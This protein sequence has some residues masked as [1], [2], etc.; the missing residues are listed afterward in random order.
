MKILISFL[1][2]LILF[3]SCG[4][5]PSIKLA[6][7]SLEA[8]VI[9]P[10]KKLKE[11]FEVENSSSEEVKIDSIAAMKGTADFANEVE[12]IVPQQSQSISIIY[13]SEKKSGQLVDSIKLFSNKKVLYKLPVSA[14]IRKAT[15]NKDDSTITIIPFNNSTSGKLSRRNVSRLSRTLMSKVSKYKNFEFVNPKQVIKNIKEDPS[16]DKSVTQT[17]LRKWGKILGVRYVMTGKV[18]TSQKKQKGFDIYISLNDVTLEQPIVKRKMGIPK[19]RL[20][21]DG[22]DFTKKILS[23][24][25]KNRKK[26]LARK[27]QEQYM[28]KRKKML[29]KK[30]PNLT[31]KNLQ[32]GNNF[33]LN[34][35]KGSNVLMHFFSIECKACKKEIKWMKEMKSEYEDLKVVGVSVDIDLDKKVKDFIKEIGVDYPILLPDNQEQD[36]QIAEYYSGATPQTL[37]INKNMIIKEYSMGFSKSSVRKFEKIVEKTL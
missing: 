20:S 33:S 13:Q 34:K 6:P 31:L 18:A 16:F 2:I 37:F 24:L 9:L 19:K 21:E 30:A 17:L 26:A 28:K 25:K 29:G 27:F 32:T 12:S 3:T 23:N 15:L 8:G 11:E 22:W 5:S 14:E 36:D 7:A 4:S 1:S 10:H 35:L